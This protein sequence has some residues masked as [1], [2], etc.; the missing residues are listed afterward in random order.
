MLL[1][2]C[3]AHELGSIPFGQQK[4]ALRRCT[5]LK[6]FI[7]RREWDKEVL[8]TR[9]ENFKQGNLP[10]GEERGSSMQIISLVLT[11]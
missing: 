5:K 8:L 1:D 3:N 4:G 10:L 11:R 6:T 7:D 9:V 2:L